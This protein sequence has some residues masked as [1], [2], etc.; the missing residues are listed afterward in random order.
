M[1][2][3]ERPPR[4]EPDDREPESGEPREGARRLVERMLREGVRRAVERGVEQI[5]ET[6]ENLR[7]FI[8]DLKLPR[9]VAAVLLQQA[10]ETKNG[11]YRAVA[12][13]LRD[14]LEQTNLAE[15]ITRA[16]TTLSF[17]IKTEIR[18]I[19]NDSKVESDPSGKLPRP[20][21]K[22]SVRVRDSRDTKDG[23]E[24]REAR[25]TKDTND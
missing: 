18:F 23:R 1:P 13:E 22:A 20:E 3:S 8:H 10:D 11:L 19:P 5:T 21:V 7:Q 6:P 17:E 2:P 16:L 4:V 14:F 12:R 9:E 25:D 24:A 15:E